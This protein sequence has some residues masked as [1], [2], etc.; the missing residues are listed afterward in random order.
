M[1]LGG[2]F[3]KTVLNNLEPVIPPGYNMSRSSFSW[4]WETARR[5]Y[6]LFGVLRIGNFFI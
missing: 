2:D 3:L 1:A 5:R 4:N 6:G